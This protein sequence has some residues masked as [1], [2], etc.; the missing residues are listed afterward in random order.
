MKRP[1]ALTAMASKAMAKAMSSNAIAR[2][3]Q[4]PV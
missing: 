4:S 2:L 3:L 1:I